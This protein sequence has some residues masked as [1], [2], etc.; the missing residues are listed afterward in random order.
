MNN[1]I[2]AL[3][4]ALHLLYIIQPQPTYFFLQH[5]LHTL[6]TQ[7]DKFHTTDFH[8]LS[9]E[10]AIRRSSALRNAYDRFT[11]QTFKMNSFIF[12]TAAL[13]FQSLVSAHMLLSYPPAF[14][15]EGNP[16]VPQ[17]L[18]DYSLTSPLN[19]DGS[20]FPCKGYQSDLGSAAGTSV[21]TWSVGGTYNFTLGGSATHDGGSCQAA[22][23]YDKGKTFTVI[24]SY[25]GGC[26]VVT[27]A[28]GSF[29]FQIPSDAPTGA[30]MFA[31]TWFNEV[32]N[33]E[34]YMDCASVTITGSGSSKRARKRASTPFSS[35]PSLFVANLGNGCTTIE[36]TDTTFP[37][38]GPDVTDVTK[39]PGGVTGTCKQVAGIG[40]FSSA[41][42]S[43]ATAPAD[44]SAAASSAA[45]VDST[46]SADIGAGTSAA[47]SPT[48]S[49]YSTSSAN[50]G[51]GTIVTPASSYAAQTSSDSQAA[52]L[53]SAASTASAT[54]TSTGGLSLSSD[55]SCGGSFGCQGSVYGNCCSEWGWCGSTSAYCG[56][57]CQ[58]EFGTC[59]TSNSS[60]SGSSSSSSSSSLQVSTDKTCGPTTSNTCQG[61]TYGNCCS[62]YG[63]CGNTSDY[64]GAGCQAGF[65]TCEESSPGSSPSSAASS[66]PSVV[67][68][69]AAASQA[70]SYPNNTIAETI[71]Y[72]NTLIQTGG[73]YTAASSSS[74]NSSGFVSVTQ[75]TSQASGFITMVSPTTTSISTS[76]SSSYTPDLVTIIPTHVRR[77]Y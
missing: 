12:L 46:S 77:R 5:T 43:A 41:S 62:Q 9:S 23:S 56:A 61:S 50:N 26:P 28:G 36:G 10:Q 18:I 67:A 6:Q 29:N 76:I 64:C 74:A 51:A 16:N 75:T 70:V 68:S 73:A 52:T 21:A 32:G 15:Y 69:S 44:S 38:P 55:G 13:G 2:R 27:P 63:Y 59:G 30:A 45:P 54:G 7:K 49:V 35:R 24:H 42:G 53:S 17:N 71:T 33:R 39:T 14:R 47:A 66:S 40:D 72:T 8:K 1:R 57:G 31:W 11:I 20:N 34:M 60:S 3:F 37:D 65:G 4:I 19:A 22:L 58:S 25:L 48:T